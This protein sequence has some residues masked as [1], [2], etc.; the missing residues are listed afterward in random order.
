VTVQAVFEACIQVL[1]DKGIER[2]TTTR[3]AARAG[4]SV[5]TLYQY[6]PNKEAL[7]AAVLQHHLSGVRDAVTGIEEGVRG[8]SLAEIVDALI[9]ALFDAKFADP[10]TSKALY[11]V[12][13]VV[14]ESDAVMR[15]TMEAQATII[16][17]LSTA[18]DRSFP[19]VESA[20]FILSTAVTGPV[21]AL[22]D[23]NGSVVQIDNVRQQLKLLSLAYLRAV[24][25]CHAVELDRA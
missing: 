17:L 16:R 2:L 4:V 1:L 24:S 11:A 25:T 13:A 14:G 7:L 22:L 21:Q 3:V 6:F 15:L 5:G 19:H 18:S 9:N 23:R 12:V 10:A 8:K 20:S